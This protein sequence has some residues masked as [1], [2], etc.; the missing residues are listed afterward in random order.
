MREYDRDRE[1]VPREEEDQPAPRSSGERRG[2]KKKKK[3]PVV[4]HIFRAVASLIC[5]GIIAVMIFRE[6]RKK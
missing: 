2:R 5:L 1:R 6:Q 4:R 3:N